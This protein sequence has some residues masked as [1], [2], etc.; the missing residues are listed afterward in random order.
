[1]IAGSE[2]GFVILGGEHK[3]SMAPDLVPG[4]NY[5]SQGLDDIDGDDDDAFLV[6]VVDDD[7]GS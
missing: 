3:I 5:V 6:V 2:S 7:D 4:L 1:M